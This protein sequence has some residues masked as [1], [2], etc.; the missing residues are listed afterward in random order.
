MKKNELKKLL[1]KTDERYQKCWDILATLKTKP[2]TSIQLFQ[3]ALCKA[4]FDLS[5]AYRTI[6]QE[7]KRL[8]ARKHLLSSSWFSKRQKLLAGRQKA[9]M[10]AVAIGRTMG[11]SFAWLFYSNDLDLLQQHLKHPENNHIPPGFGGIGEKEFVK[12][13]LK[14]GEYMV[15]YHGTTTLLRLGDVSLIDLKQF[16][17]A[18]I[19]DLKTTPLEPGKLSI[20]LLVMGDKRIL[21]VGSIIPLSSSPNKFLNNYPPAMKARIDRQID[22]NIKALSSNDSVKNASHLKLTIETYIPEFQRMLQT[23]KVGRFSYQQFGDGLLCVVF[24]QRKQNL[25]TTI[26]PA[27]NIHLSR[28]LDEV[29][30]HACKLALH[31][32]P[33]N[34]LTLGSFLYQRDGTPKYQLGTLPLFWWPLNVDTIKNLIFQEYIVVIIYNSAHFISKLEAAGFTLEF[35]KDRTFNLS[36]SIGK[37]K[38]H[39][40][41]LRYFFELICSYFYKEV[42]VIEM[43]KRSIQE[44]EK[45]G[46]NENARYEFKFDHRLFF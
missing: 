44:I 30:A 39:V 7:R 32:S 2:D 45:V 12:R 26:A 22:R 18:G 41:G 43:L 10:E 35:K 38:L 23:A 40:T 3:A 1:L 17:V 21:P 6:S 5:N 24:K 19:G 16:R 15:L 9:I 46:V 13:V 8:I 36:Y 14:L 11:D 37:G 20:T 27:K 42:E 34:N 4:L 33:H 31:G 25:H 28:K 29:A